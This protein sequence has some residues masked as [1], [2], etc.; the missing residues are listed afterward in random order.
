MKLG[1]KIKIPKNTTVSKIPIGAK[2]EYC[3]EHIEVS[4]G[5]GNHHTMSLIMSVDDWEALK[6]KEELYFD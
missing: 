6:N 5:I 2:T 4:I 1:R 3:T